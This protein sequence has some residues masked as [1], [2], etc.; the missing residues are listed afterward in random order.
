MAK[1]TDEE[2][3]RAAQAKGG[4]GRDDP[5]IRKAAKELVVFPNAYPDRE[6]VVRIECPEFTAVCPMPEQPDFVGLAMLAVGYVL[7]ALSAPPAFV[8]EN[9]IPP[10]PAAAP[11]DTQTVDSILA[12]PLS[13]S[14]PATATNEPG[15]ASRGADPAVVREK[16]ERV[17]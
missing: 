6:Y 8:A 14:E 15:Q 7:G 17:K 1:L 9:G 13:P 12:A 10:A 3:A 11:V 16:L 2:R 4:A 5:R